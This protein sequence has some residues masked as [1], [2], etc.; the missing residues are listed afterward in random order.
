MVLFRQNWDE[1]V[2]CVSALV[3]QQQL[4]EKG[5]FI[6]LLLLSREQSQSDGFGISL[7]S[8]TSTFFTCH[9]METNCFYTFLP[10]PSAE[11][12][13]TESVSNVFEEKSFVYLASLFPE[14]RRD[15][16]SEHKQNNLSRTVDY[17]NCCNHFN[18]VSEIIFHFSNFRVMFC[19]SSRFLSFHFDCNP[20]NLLAK[21]F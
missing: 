10:P 9:L 1:T 15:N 8:S 16:K 5:F 18:M 2:T 7:G 19:A 12:L 4:I 14:S 17:V 21:G 3:C 13:Q 6:K 20:E 11:N